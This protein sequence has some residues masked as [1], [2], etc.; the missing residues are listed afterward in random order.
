V[1]KPP[2][3]LAETNYVQSAVSLPS[4]ATYFWMRF[5]LEHALRNPLELKD[6][7]RLP[8][9]CSDAMYRFFLFDRARI[10]EFK[11]VFAFYACDVTTCYYIARM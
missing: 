10:D 8:E 5:I 1:L 4:K 7:G 11:R 6:L 9:V 3:S 2:E